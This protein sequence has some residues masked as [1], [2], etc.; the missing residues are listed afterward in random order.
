MAIEDIPREAIQAVAALLQQTLPDSLLWLTAFARRTLEYVFAPILD[1]GGRYPWF[2]LVAALG[3]AACA[4]LFDRTRPKGGGI[5]GFLPF[6]FPPAIWRSQS[7]WVDLKVG[8]FNYFLFGGGALNVTW[9]FTTALF[10]SWIT[11][12][13]TAGFGP[14]A[15]HASWGPVSIVL[16]ALAIS[17][18]S[19]FGYFLFHWLAH[20]FPPLWAIHKLHH[21]AEVMTPLTAARVHALEHPIT[22]PFMALTTGVLVGPLLYLYGGET[23]VPTIFGLD[24]AGAMFFLLGHNLHHSHV[25]VYFGPIIGRV[26]VSPAQHQIHHSCLPRHLDKNFAEHWAFWD[27]IFGTLYLPQGRETLTLGLAGYSEQPHT[28]VL[29]AN[30]RPV[31]DSVITSVRMVRRGMA[32]LRRWREP[33]AGLDGSLIAPNA[34]DPGQ[35]F[36]HPPGPGR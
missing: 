9:R 4:F 28:G 30:I 20:V 25:W 31:V 29:A 10:A 18:A 19:D 35:G 15:H 11:V 34:P 22:G 13:L 26:I 5:R 16:F 8:F 23:T 17:M 1:H 3:I 6:C 7:A 27:T 2:G 33:D 32:W 21:S 36:A 24:M 14:I 12:M